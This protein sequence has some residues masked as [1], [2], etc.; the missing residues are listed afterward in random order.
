MELLR[1]VDLFLGG[2]GT[3]KVRWPFSRR[4]WNFRG[5]LTF[6]W[7]AWN[8]QGPLIFLSKSENFW[9]L[10]TGNGGAPQRAKFNEVRGSLGKVWEVKPWKFSDIWKS[11]RSENAVASMYEH[12]KINHF[13]YI[14]IYLSGNRTSKPPFFQLWR[15]LVKKK[16]H[17]VYVLGHSGRPLLRPLKLPLMS[18]SDTSVFEY[19]Q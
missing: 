5:P 9:D 15:H 6:F 1:S 8:F 14:R 17:M 12:T 19:L 4:A 11:L 2:R 7:R 16:R 13:K 18:S 10:G 3:F